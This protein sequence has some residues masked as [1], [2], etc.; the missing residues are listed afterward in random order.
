VGRAP[1][2][3]LRFDQ[4]VVYARKIA[5]DEFTPAHLRQIMQLR[6]DGDNLVFPD[7]RWRSRLLGEGE[8]KAVYLVCDE[9]S[10]VF[11][12]ELIDERYYLNGRLADGTYFASV[13]ADA[14]RRG[15]TFR[16][17]FSGLVKVREYVHGYEWSR[18]RWRPDRPRPLDLILTTYLRVRFA[19][20]YDSYRARYGDVHERNI[21]FEVRPLRERG[22]LVVVR[23]AVGRWCLA[24][25]GLRPVDV[26]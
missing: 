16:R 25:V 24:K 2:I 18:F 13:R 6:Q 11:A 12:V 23:D 5:E 8:E 26:R 3:P 20:R 4:D 1:L 9:N 21:L 17:Q 15:G 14:S 7:H 19:G 10:R 22:A